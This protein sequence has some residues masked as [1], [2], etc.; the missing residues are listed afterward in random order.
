MSESSEVGGKKS[1]FAK[2]SSCY[3]PPEGIKNPSVHSGR[4]G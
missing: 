4:A 1:V 2:N 3:F